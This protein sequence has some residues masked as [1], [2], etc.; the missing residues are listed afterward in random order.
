MLITMNWHKIIL[1]IVSFYDR[2]NWP[3]DGARSCVCVCVYS[4][5]LTIDETAIANRMSPTSSGQIIPFD[6]FDCSLSK[7]C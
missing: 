3:K 1:L 6:Q 7:L 4:W 2:F 5:L